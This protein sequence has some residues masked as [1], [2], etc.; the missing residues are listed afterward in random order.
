[1]KAL[2]ALLLT[3]LA[4]LPGESPGA[5]APAVDALAV[6][7]AVCHDALVVPQL[8]LSALPAGIAPA[9]AILV[10]AVAGAQHGAD[11]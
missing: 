11:A 5:G 3:L 6:A 1:M 8:A 10:V 2:L 4:G 7:A 9:R